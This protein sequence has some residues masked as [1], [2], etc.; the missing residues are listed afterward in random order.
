MSE[1]NEA[2]NKSL[3]LR[4]DMFGPAGAEKAAIYESTLGA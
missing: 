1:G 4:R 2:F 3:A